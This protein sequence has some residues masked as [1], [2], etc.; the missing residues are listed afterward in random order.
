[1]LTLADIQSQINTENFIGGEPVKATASETYTSLNP[2]D[3]QPIATFA[4]SN[5]EDTSRAIAAARK[6]FD[7]GPWPRMSVAERVKLINRF[8]SLIE[9]KAE[10]LGAIES[11][12]VGKLLGEC[13]GHDVARASANM[14]FFASKMEQW[15]DEAYFKDAAFLGRKIKTLSIAKRE[16][17]GV[18]GII[19]PWNSPIMLATWKLGPCIAAGNTCVLKASPWA[20]LTILQ[21]GQ[22]AK[23]AGIPDGVMNFIAGGAEAGQTL[24]SHPDVDRVSFTGSVGVGKAVNIANAQAR[25]APVSLELGGKSPSIVFDDADLDMA[26]AGVARGIFR[27][28]GQ[29]CVAGSRLLL[30]ESIYNEFMPRLVKEVKA[31]KIGSQLDSSSQIGPLITKEHLASIERMVQAGVSAGAKATIGGRR[32]EGVEFAQGNYF[33]PTIFEEVSSEMEVWQEEIFGPVLCVMPFKDESDAIA[34][35]N[36]SEFGLSSS[37]WTTDMDR[38]MTV[39]SAIESGM[40]W[41]NAHFVRDLRSPFGGVKDSGIGSEGGRYSLEFYTRAKMICLTYPR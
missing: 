23:D 18:A 33:E 15:E 7:Q 10:F 32:P 2:S 39:S 30:Q 12:D 28:Q 19:V 17:A 25:M 13:V 27:S 34:K 31:M 21:L 4:L 20:Q 8:A 1:M 24:T 9:E 5:A 3:N 41:V 14:R 11:Y 40:T 29:S 22:L 36:D 6:A 37:V 35:A 26:V 16:P 38:A